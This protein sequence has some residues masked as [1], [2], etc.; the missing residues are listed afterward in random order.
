MHVCVRKHK[1]VI[2]WFNLTSFAAC[3]QILAVKSSNKVRRP[4]VFRVAVTV[5][6]NRSVYHNQGFCNKTMFNGPSIVA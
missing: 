4:E 1:V 5:S 6:S 2:S 3:L